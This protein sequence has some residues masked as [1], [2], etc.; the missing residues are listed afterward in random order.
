[1]G[2]IRRCGLLGERMS[3]GL[4]LRF[5]SLPPSPICHS[6]PLTCCSRYGLLAAAPAIY[7]LKQVQYGGANLYL[8]H[9]QGR[10]KRF[11]VN[12]SDIVAYT[13]NDPVHK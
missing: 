4:S 8:L 9:L 13:E 5:Q 2:R 6:L 1:M 7:H 10:D 3:L 12:L 11:K